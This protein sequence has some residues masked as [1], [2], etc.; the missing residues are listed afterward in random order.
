MHAKDVL[1]EFWKKCQS[2]MGV[3]VELT[4]NFMCF[5]VR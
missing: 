1:S 4:E 3:E 5:G 2:Q